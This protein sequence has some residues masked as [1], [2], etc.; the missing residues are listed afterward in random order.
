MPDL[1][2]HPASPNP[3]AEKSPPAAQTRVGWIP[4]QGRNDGEVAAGLLSRSG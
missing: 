4:A 1:I 2:L 3:W